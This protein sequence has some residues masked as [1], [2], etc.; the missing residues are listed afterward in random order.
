MNLI[1]SISR[2]VKLIYTD[3]HKMKTVSELIEYISER[4]MEKVAVLLLIIWVLSPIMVMFYNTTIQDLLQINL[5]FKQYPSSIYWYQILQT[6]GFIGCIVGIIIFSKSVLQAKNEKISLNEYI[7]NN[8]LQICLFAMILWSILSCLN[9]DN[10]D[11]S[12]NGT[13]YRKEGVI[14]YF[15]YLGIFSCGY[16][17]RDKRLIKIILEIFTLSA[18]LLSILTL[19]DFKALNDFLGLTSDSSIF[20]QFNHY[21]YYLCM[22]IMCTLVLFV[23]EKRSILKLIF[24]II[25]L[26]VITAALIKNGSLGP[27]LAVIVGLFSSVI[28]TLW[29]DKGTLKRVAVVVSTF[30]IVTAAMNISNSHTYKDFEVLGGDIFEIVE[31]SSDADKAGTGRWVL[32]RNGVRFISERPLFGYGPDNL[33]DQY[34][35]V[36]V[37]T[38]RPHNEIIQFAAS[39]GIPAAIFY[40]IAVFNYFIVFLRNRKHVLRMEIGLLC[41]VITYLASSMFGNTMYYT[42]P[43]FFMILGLSVGIQAPPRFKNVQLI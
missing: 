20:Y 7:K 3:I 15:T 1:N 24:R 41:T 4:L 5:I 32:W 29:L 28:F 39:L 22:S 26:S 6:I 13:L 33:G 17:V 36:N 35:K 30:L 25:T 23:T 42:S 31:K 9:S 18:M 38:D 37:G 27:Y 21:A 11:I 34:A 10:I 14:T 40:I 12:L 19:I 8:L 43:F 2:K 16:M